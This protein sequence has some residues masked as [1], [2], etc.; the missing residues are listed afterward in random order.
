MAPAGRGSPVG[1][2]RHSGHGAQYASPPLSETMRERGVRPPTG[3]ASSP[4][5]SAAMGSPM[6]IAK[7]E[8]VHARV[9][10]S[11]EEAALGLFERMEVAYS[12]A[13]IHSAPGYL[14]PDESERANWPKEESRPQAA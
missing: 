9:Y 11:R 1:R 10:A 5:G 6:G 12:R 8:C 2:I 13:R 7:P 4:W 14:S 3:S